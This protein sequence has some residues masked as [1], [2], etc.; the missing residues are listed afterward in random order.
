MALMAV[1]YRTCVSVG[2]DTPDAMIRTLTTALE[3]SEYAEARLDY[4]DPDSVLPMLDSLPSSVLRKRIVCTVRPERDGGRFKGTERDR[5]EL[6]HNV[7]AYGPY[8]LDVELD[9]LQK[10]RSLADGLVSDSGVRVLASWHSFDGM[11]EATILHRRL[12]SMARYSPYLKI[13]CMARDVSESLRM[14]DLYG[15]LAALE[16]NGGGGSRRGRRRSTLVSFAMGD[17][18][19]LTRVLCL[20]LG[21]PY[22]YVSLGRALAP[23]QLS[24]ADVRELGRMLG[25]SGRIGG[26]TATG[27]SGGRRPHG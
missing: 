4:V 2:E 23:G 3:G 17:A 1:R 6:L 7:A 8:L 11:P 19:R 22:T 25:G 9:T 26:A 27:G 5:R 15:W 21:S 14:L 13:A 20:H 10:S 12:R 18:G 16:R 24:L